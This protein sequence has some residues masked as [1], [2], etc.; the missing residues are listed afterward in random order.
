MTENNQ[1]PQQRPARPVPPQPQN[2]PAFAA[3]DQRSAANDTEQFGSPAPDAARQVPAQ[4]VPAQ[5]QTQPLTSPTLQYGQYAPGTFGQYAAPSYGPDASSGQGGYG[6]HGQGATGFGSGTAAGYGGQQTATSAKKRFGTG[7][8]IAGMLLAGLA[9]GGVAVGSQAL[10]DGTAGTSIAGS[11]AKQLIVN[12]TDS[13]NEITAAAAKA[14]PSVVTISVA[15]GNTGGSGSGIIL[16]TEG[17]I[18]TNTH[19]VTLGGQTS[20]PDVEV[21]TSD[22]NVHKA[23]VVGTDPLSDLAVIK[24][25]AE[26]L[27]PATF[28]DSGKLNVGDTTIAIGAPLGLA[29]TVTDGIVSTLSRTI[30]VSSSAVPENSGDSA[31]PSPGDQF[32]FQ[33]PGEEQSANQG[34]IF[35]NVIQTDAAINHGNSGGALVN[36]KGE[37]IGVNV[38]IASAS[39]DSGSIGV[40]FAIPSNYAQ[41]VAQELIKDGSASHGMLGVSVTA[42]ASGN[43]AGNTQFSVGADVVEVVKD[44]PAAKA[45]LQKGDVITGVENRVIG[46]SQSLTAAIREHAAGSTVKVTYLRGGETRTADVTLSEG[47]A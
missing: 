21:R 38:A 3:G 8:L 37:I 2:P 26:G 27:T 35:M 19:V 32:N 30:S 39:Q 28:G 9:G 31:Q 40:G 45:G 47:Q 25:D 16:D 24:I 23:K 1:D 46:D 11:P 34:S 43:S 15:S 42:K 29:G 5:E 41:R 44:S 13:V 20:S 22:G 36:T 12:N 17:H 18:L 14:S 4:G 10:A 6:S 7:T 33:F